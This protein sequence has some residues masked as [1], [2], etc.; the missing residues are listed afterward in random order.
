MRGDV[1]LARCAAFP[2]RIKVGFSSYLRGRLT[3]M[4]RQY[5]G[6][7]EIVAAVSGSLENE[8]RL[9]S[10]LTVRSCAVGKRTWYWDG[11][12]FPSLIE[13]MQSGTFRW[14]RCLK[15]LRVC[16]RPCKA[17]IFIE[18]KM[19]MISEICRDNLLALADSYASAERVPFSTVSKRFYGNTNFLRRFQNREVSISI[20]KF[21]EV[22][23]R[24]IAK[25]PPDAE[26]PLLRNVIIK[27]PRK[28]RKG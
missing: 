11:P 19:N 6:P 4:R 18:L 5:G 16:P 1:Y 22:I 25:W 17:E 3:E 14:D 9:H 8:T 10:L 15:S 24:F 2:K 23:E 12:P 26:W 13:Q 27:G 28:K 7:V 20:D 21:D